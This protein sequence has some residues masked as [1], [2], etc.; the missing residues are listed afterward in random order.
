MRLR[1]LRNF[2]CLGD[3]WLRAITRGALPALTSLDLGE[4][5]EQRVLEIL[6]ATRELVRSKRFRSITFARLP[7]G[8]PVATWEGFPEDA[9]P[10][11]LALE[12]RGEDAEEL[13]AFLNS[14]ALARCVSLELFVPPGANEVLLALAGSPHA[15]HLRSLEVQGNNWI[16]GGSF[17]T[18]TVEALAGSGH[19]AGLV[20]L[21]FPHDLRAGGLRALMQA[22]FAQSLRRLNVPGY[23]CPCPK[24]V[25]LL[26]TDPNVFPNLLELTL[27]RPNRVTE[28]ER[29]Q[30]GAA[31]EDR[32]RFLYI[33]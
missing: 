4:R 6:D 32:F 33:G 20:N 24:E 17:P 1:E 25:Y 3:G 22:T 21:S 15:R 16:G 8:L 19:L 30:V 29:Q 13:I 11:T 28:E 23:M 31:L 12:Y 14:P 10:P 26:M 2:R 9:G 18:S 27:P 7:G 5:S